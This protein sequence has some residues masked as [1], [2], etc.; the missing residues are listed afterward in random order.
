MSFEEFAP[1]LWISEVWFSPL[2]LRSTKMKRLQ[3]QWSHVLSRITNLVLFNVESGLQGPKLALSIHGEHFNL[4]AKLRF[5]MTDGDGFAQGLSWKGASSLKPCLV[6]WNVQMLTRDS[7]PPHVCVNAVKGFLRSTDAG[8]FGVVDE[9]LVCRRRVENKMMTKTRFEL[10]EKQAGFRAEPLSFLANTALRPHYSFPGLVFWDW[11]HIF[12]QDG[13]LNVELGAFLTACKAFKV[14]EAAVGQIISWSIAMQWQFPSQSEKTISDLPSLIKEM[15][16]GKT[17][18]TIRCG[19]SQLLTAFPVLRHYIDTEIL[20]DE[21][22]SV[23]RASL[24]LAFD[25]VSALHEC[26]HG[27]RTKESLADSLSV[28]WPRWLKG[29][30]RCY[31]DTYVKPTF[32]WASHLPRQFLELFAD[33]LVVERMNKRAKN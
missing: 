2:L 33:M 6:C 7:E 19:A 26:K 11:F 12:L 9:L 29:Y 10:L 31:Q 16:Q 23:H 17:D 20:P 32:H 5:V 21:R 27:V 1:Y 14:A 4:F 18:I 22:L 25:M 13:I 15:C 24:R 30:K 3:G 8:T 28:L